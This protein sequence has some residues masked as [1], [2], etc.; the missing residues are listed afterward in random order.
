MNSK[1]RSADYELRRPAVC[2]RDCS[3]PGHEFAKGGDGEVITGIREYKTTDAFDSS[4]TLEGV[5][6]DLFYARPKSGSGKTATFGTT[7]VVDYTKTEFE[8]D[9]EKEEFDADDSVF[10]CRCDQHVLKEVPS[11]KADLR[12]EG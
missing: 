2:V 6:W 11:K 4:K 3:G 7:I 10:L 5:E 9:V 1:D 8:G 12:K